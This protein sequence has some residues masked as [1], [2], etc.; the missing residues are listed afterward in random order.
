MKKEALNLFKQA[1]ECTPDVKDGFRDGLQALGSNAKNVMSA[2]SRKID[3]SVDIDS[4]THG[5]YPNES[6][7]DYTIGY[8]GK[9]YFL[10][11]HP[12]NTS[13]VKEI[14]KKADWLKKWLSEKAVELKK[15]A[16]KNTFYWVP[17]GK[18]SILP[19]SPQGRQLAQKN[20]QLIKRLHL[21][22]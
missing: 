14:V 1:I 10:E 3:G 12:A 16:A 22:I 20:I 13:N 11:V 6:R 7:W 21:P 9:A 2:N 17:S 4:C 5:L 18:Y 19:S 15:I 8:D